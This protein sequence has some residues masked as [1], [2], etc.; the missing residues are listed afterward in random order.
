[1]N[2]CEKC[3]YESEKNKSIDEEKF[4]CSIC[5]QFAPST[6]QMNDYLQDKL[7]WKALEPLRKFSR[8]NLQGM[9][10]KAQ[11]GQVMS[12]AAL[13]YKFDNKSLVPDE[14]LKLQIQKIFLEF[15]NSEVSLN[16]L[17]K[18]FGLSVNGLKKVLRNFT[19]I[20][21]VKFNGQILRG[22]HE[23]I[24]S[25]EIFNRAQAKLESLNIK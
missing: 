3:G 1:M 9:T 12:R 21:K 22:N 14:E 17:S 8:K 6:E 24:I 13:G 15:I 11:Q 19:Y 20:G 2:K 18:K 10:S 4:L 5:S 25:S 16:Q 7:D 23:P